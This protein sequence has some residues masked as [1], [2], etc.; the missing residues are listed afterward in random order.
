V[1]LD[2]I[3]EMPLEMQPKLLRAIEAQEIRR[4]GENRA[5]KIDVRVVAATHRRLEREINHGRFRE[6]LYFRLSVVT[7]RVPPLRERIDD[8]TMLV[9]VLLEQLGATEAARL[10]SP[11]VLA[12]MARY[13][14]PGNVRELRNYIE[15]T[16]VLDAPA[17]SLK[18]RESQRVRAGG[19]PPVAPSI[20][21]AF[22][23]AK[24][25][26]V[27]AFEQQYLNALVAWAGGNISR[28]ARKAGLD[29]MYLYRLLQRHGLR[30]ESIKD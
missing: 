5:R 19:T 21:V 28:A 27:T 8:L 23:V 17:P 24:D 6:D 1:F 11:E 22:R 20:E 4:V 18:A 13:E 10:F 25:D 3:G 15:R 30:P 7:V 2:E 9:H 14:W 26:V 16:V 29:R 12:E